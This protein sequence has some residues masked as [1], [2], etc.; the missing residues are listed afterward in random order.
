MN[1]AINQLIEHLKAATTPVEIAK[2]TVKL[3]RACGIYNV[4]GIGQELARIAVTSAPEG[5]R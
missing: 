4:Q 2:V 5:G 3:L 1:Q